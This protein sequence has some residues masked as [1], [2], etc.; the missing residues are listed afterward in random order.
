MSAR[1]ATT[2]PPLPS[3]AITLVSVGRSTS[4]AEALERVGHERRGLVLVEADL[5]IA[6][7]VPPPGDDVFV[8]PRHPRCLPAATVVDSRRVS[9]VAR[10][11]QRPR[12]R[13]RHDGPRR[14]CSRTAFGCDQNMW[15]FVRAAR[16]RPTIASCCSTTSAPAAS[17]LQRVRPACATARSA[18]T[19]ARRDRQSGSGAGL[20]RVTRSFVLRGPT[21][22]AGGPG[23]D[24][25]LAVARPDG[26][27]RGGVRLP[28]SIRV[29][30]N[31]R[32]YAFWQAMLKC[33]RG[34]VPMLNVTPPTTV[35]PDGS[36][37]RTETYTI[38]Y[39][40]APDE[41][42][43][44]TSAAASWPTARSARCGR[45]WCGAS[46]ASATTR[47]SVAHR[48]GPRGRSSP[49]EVLGAREEVAAW[50]GLSAAGP[51]APPAP[52]AAARAAVARAAGDR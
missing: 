19:P 40:T 10:P 11:Q 39:T 8:D 17:D 24:A 43:R 20:P 25:G 12:V 41:R 51:A 30:K 7:Q 50:L 9:D 29:A 28:V 42:Y 15:R 37:S 38:R 4:Q 16:S 46:P 45:G 49:A 14:W 6:V 47:A 33:R 18:A 21:A 35:R 44:V 13:T 34:S 1:S 5:G 27:V 23:R 31:G 52:V 26:A 36:F 48:T 2:G 22:P 32:I 3:R